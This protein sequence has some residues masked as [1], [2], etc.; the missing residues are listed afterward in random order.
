MIRF[1]TLKPGIT[2]WERGR[3]VFIRSVNPIAMTAVVS[4]D[5]APD[6]ELGADR[7]LLLNRRRG[8]APSAEPSLPEQRHDDE[9]EHEGERPGLPDEHEQKPGEE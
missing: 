5:G 4:I 8:A 2:L 7:L 1:A 3:S 6:E 9:Q